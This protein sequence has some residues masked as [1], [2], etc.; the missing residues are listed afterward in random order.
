MPRGD[1][2]G[3]EGYGP[4]SGR[5]LG[6]CRGYSSPGYTKGT[7]RGWGLGRGFGRG[8][9]RGFGGGFGWRNRFR[10]GYDYEN[11]PPVAPEP[12]MNPKDET[13]LLKEEADALK[14]DLES[15]NS[16]IKELEEGKSKE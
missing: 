16:R 9:G 7:P 12:P 3:P 2:T 11:F 1:R 8:Y 14:K 10:G 4:M 6:Y 15:I 13:R 5:G